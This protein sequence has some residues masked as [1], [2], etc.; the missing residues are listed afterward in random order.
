MNMSFSS[1]SRKAQGHLIP[2]ENVINLLTEIDG[3]NSGTF[4]IID[5]CIVLSICCLKATWHRSAHFI[6]CSAEIRARVLHS[7][8]V[9][10]QRAVVVEWIQSAWC[11]CC[12]I[13]SDRMTVI[14]ALNSFTARLSVAMTTETSLTRWSATSKASVIP[15]SRTCRR[16]RVMKRIA[17]IHWWHRV[18]SNF[19]KSAVRRWSGLHKF[20]A[21]KIWAVILL[22]DSSTESSGV[23]AIQMLRRGAKGTERGHWSLARVAMAA[24]VTVSASVCLSHSLSWGAATFAAVAGGLQFVVGN[25]FVVRYFRAPWKAQIIKF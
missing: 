2:K 18:T 3:V 8:T 17:A 12:W 9:G 20:M 25:W 6:Q 7:G 5:G 21:C 24:R 15:T 11:C 23:F 10:V 4:W 13:V 14:T 1:R 16:D 22:G 19:G